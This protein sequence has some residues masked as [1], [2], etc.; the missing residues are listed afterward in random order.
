MEEVQ[1]MLQN[2]NIRIKD[3]KTAKLA[4]AHNRA[5]ERSQQNR[6]RRRPPM[7][8]SVRLSNTDS[9]GRANRI[10]QRLRS[11]L[12]EV[13]SSSLEED[14]RKA[15]ARNVQLQLDRV[16]VKIRQIRRRERAQ[17][18]EKRERSAN[19]RQEEDR[20]AERIREERRRRRQSDMRQ[21]S[22]RVR[23]D[24]LHPASEGGF[25]PYNNPITTALTMGAI[26]SVGPAVALDIGG[27]SGVVTDSAP[28]A[29]DVV[30]MLM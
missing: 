10:R 8:G 20:R 14:V 30:N 28:P 15:L 6:R 29:P 4:E 22:I 27:Y 3:E 19:K 26:G 13:M 7:Q 2:V 16:E 11:K 12:G 23:R 21:R 24:M 18:E 25:D 5:N 1:I 9:L 17:E